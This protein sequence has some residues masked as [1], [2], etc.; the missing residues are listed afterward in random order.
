MLT[1]RHDL[2][3]Y[4]EGFT[5][6]RGNEAEQRQIS[7][8]RAGEVRATLVGNGLTAVSI[9][10]AGFGRTRPLGSNA[11]ASGREQNRRVE[12]VISG[13]SIGGMALWD[14]TYPLSSRH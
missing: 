2:T 10:A 6:D 1:S 13:P 7:E 11:S 12:I 14:R 9:Q 3:I 5:D 4:V 8:R